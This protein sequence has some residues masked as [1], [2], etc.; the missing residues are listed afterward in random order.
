MTQINYVSWNKLQSTANLNFG[1]I[2]FVNKLFSSVQLIVFLD[3]VLLLAV[4]WLKKSNFFKIVVWQSD[5]MKRNYGEFTFTL[6]CYFYRLMFNLKIIT[7]LMPPLNG[8]NVEQWM[9]TS[10]PAR[11]FDLY[12][13]LI[14]NTLLSM[15]TNFSVI[16]KVIFSFF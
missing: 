7:F 11:T 9:A 13:L 14:W 5:S 10:Q 4:N 16:C 6:F 12:N 1:L 15:K 8:H 2:S 3:H